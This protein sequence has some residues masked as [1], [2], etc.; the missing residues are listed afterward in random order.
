MRPPADDLAVAAAFAG[1]LDREDYKTARSLLDDDCMYLIRG[2]RLVGPDQII[3]SYKGNGDAASAEFDSIAYSSTVRTGDE[4]WVVIEFTDEIRHAGR[5]LVHRCEQRVRV[6][7]PGR[8]VRVEH[9][10]LPGERERLEGFR[11][12]CGPR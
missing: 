10:D 6:G 1:A 2:E 7:E 5:T 9:I 4:R 3:A 12:E 11:R 8:I